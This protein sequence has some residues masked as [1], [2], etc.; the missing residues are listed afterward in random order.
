MY[1]LGFGKRDR[2]NKEL[3]G[4]FPPGS[5]VL[6]EGQNGAG[7]SA[8]SQRFASGLCEEG[9]RVTYL[10]T[11]LSMGAFLR[12]MNSLDYDMVGHVLDDDILFLH[13]DIGG[14]GT[15]FTDDPGGANDDGRGRRSP[16]RRLMQADAMWDA[17]VVVVDTFDTILRNDD[18]LEALVREGR[19]RQAAL[20][21]VSFLRSVTSSGTV[22]VLTVDSTTVDPDVLGPFR[23]VADV[24]LE[25]EMVPVG[26]EVRRQINVRRFAG[27]GAQVG[28][29]IGYSVRSDAGIVIESRS[30][31]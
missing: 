20:E 24:L 17:D 28:D 15:S 19:G 11:E 6:V 4:G 22:V 27:M 25:L 26:S 2:L 9:N 16:I 31:V 18:T 7:K 14:S 12:Q 8:L 30:V 10:S 23:S 29:T 13:A 3:G 1:S 5:L 21:V